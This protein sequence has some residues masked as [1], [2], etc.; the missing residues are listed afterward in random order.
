[1]ASHNA[2]AAAAAVSV[3]AVFFALSAVSQGVRTP[4]YESL[5]RLHS[6]CGR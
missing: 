2:N 1:V 6:S 5:R 3:A 4:T